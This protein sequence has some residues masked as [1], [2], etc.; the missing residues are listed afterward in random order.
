IPP[1]T[2]EGTKIR[3]RGQGGGRSGQ[4]GDLYLRVRLLPHPLF[5]VQENDLEGALVVMPWQAVLGDKVSAPTL[6]GTVSVTLPP[7]THAGKRLRLRGKGLPKKDNSRGDLYLRVV[8]DIPSQL[9]EKERE[10]Y[11]GLAAQHRKEE[12]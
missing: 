3:L 7:A 6:E 5:Q 8:I 2:R 9:S 10:L 12:S 11:H 4:R 1:S